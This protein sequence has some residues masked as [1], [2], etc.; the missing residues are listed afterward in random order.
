M[1][2][3]KRFIPILL[4][5]VS[6][7]A[8]GS[9]VQAEVTTVLGATYQVDEVVADEMLEKD[10][11][12]RKDIA[13][14]S[15]SLGI[16]NQSAAGSGGGGTLIAGQL[17]PQ[18]VNVL[19]VPSKNDVKIIPW[20]L[21]SNSTWTLATVT[22]LAKNFEANNPGWRVIAAVNGDF[23]DIR[24]QGN[25]PYQPSGA[26][27]SDG[28]LY[29]S[30]SSG[31]TV[32]FLNNG[33]AVSIIGG[34]PV[35]STHIYM[36]VYDEF[37]VVIDKI[38]LDKINQEPSLGETAL[39]YANWK[40][41]TSEETQAE[42]IP[43]R[44]AIDGAT[45]FIVG[46]AEKALANTP[47]DF[48]G[49]GVISEV[50]A[51]ITLTS[52]QFALVSKNG[53]IDNLLSIG[54]KVRI[55]F[56]YT[57]DFAQANGV[58]GAGSVLV[59]DGEAVDVIDDVFRH[60]RTMVG[61]RADGTIL[62]ATIDGRQPDRNMYGATRQEMSALMMHYGA[63][64]AYNLDGGGSTTMIL[65]RGNN[66]TVVNSP[67]DGSERR[68]SN[69][70]LIVSYDPSLSTLHA[71]DTTITI[72][73]RSFG[74]KNAEFSNAEVTINGVTKLIQD[75]IAHF[76]G[77]DSQSEYEVTFS[78][79]LTTLDG[80]QTVVGNPFKVRTGRS[81]PV[82][83]G[84]R[85]VA[86]T[87]LYYYLF[88]EVEDS[89]QAIIALF[90]EYEITKTARFLT[91]LS[92]VISIKKAT[93]GDNTVDGIK[94]IVVYNHQSVNTVNEEMS[95]VAV[96]DI[97]EYTVPSIVRFE[98]VSSTNQTVTFAYEINDP[99]DVQTGLLLKRG[100]S[101]TWL[102]GN[103]GTY[104]MLNIFKGVTYS[105]E[106]V[107]RHAHPLTLEEEPDVKSAVLT[108]F[109]PKSAPVIKTFVL[110]NMTLNAFSVSYDVEDPDNSVLGLILKIDEDEIGLDG[111]TGL[112]DIENLVENT[113][114]NVQLVVVYKTE[115]V[116]VEL[117]R[118]TSEM[119]SYVVLVNPVLPG[120]PSM[121]IAT[122]IAITAGGVVSASGIGVGIFFFLKRRKPI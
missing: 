52:G 119:L 85:V 5:I 51:D 99:D 29:R 80:I 60:P 90:A 83:V 121:D 97:Y 7:L 104:E 22:N 66:F 50:N 25:L 79:Q 58:I 2:T 14:S 19:A 46:S 23:F 8:T 27:M 108:H 62:F 54:T 114:I 42:I 41:K 91:D 68:D 93:V 122:V 65:R 57:S 35:K 109:N 116:Q 56:E 106:L 72:T 16:T 20:S 24:G 118:L 67:S 105:F 33:Q 112:Y 76:D 11:H 47:S 75:G 103:S 89:E 49:R 86:E 78:Y 113:T 12:Y 10:I 3:M 34:K 36:T 26:Q 92:G 71:S 1:K 111:L 88:Y 107:I 120:G 77:L 40:Q 17:Y 48:Y 87:D 101:T 28:E 9:F 63:V 59:Q 61:R 94:L 18:Q 98:I 69:G 21:T 84:A 38:A 53:F 32:G 110:V 30:T 74:V 95:L 43:V 70:L 82:I 15:A 55:Q 81:Q 45:Q 115:N 117:S 6:F 39:Y 44:V 100:N 13:S 102:E 4:L 96:E 73:Q 31:S 64:E 37:D